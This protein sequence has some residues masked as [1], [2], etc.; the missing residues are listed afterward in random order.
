MTHHPAY[1]P[2]ATLITENAVE[3]DMLAALNVNQS[4]ARILKRAIAEIEELDI[5]TAPCMARGYDWETILEQLTDVTPTFDMAQR[6]M[7][8][9]W[10]RE[11]NGE[12]V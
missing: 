5:A 6:R 11:R 3:L 12:A 2:P 9:E 7:V 10:A 8:E 4:A 1:P